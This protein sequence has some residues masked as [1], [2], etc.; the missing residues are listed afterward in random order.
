MCR[1]LYITESHYKLTMSFIN[2]CCEF[3]LLH[4]SQLL[5]LHSNFVFILFFLFVSLYGNEHTHGE[6]EA[7]EQRVGTVHRIYI[8]TGTPN[9]DTDT[10][11]HDGLGGGGDGERR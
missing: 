9:L 7:G 1:F 6:A 10:H 3:Y 8:H 5:R 4:R 2:C 11:I